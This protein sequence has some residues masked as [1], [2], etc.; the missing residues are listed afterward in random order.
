MSQ[1]DCKRCGDAGYVAG[2]ERCPECQGSPYANLDG[3]TMV[4]EACHGTG[5]KNVPCPEC[6]KK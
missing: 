4:C 1:H 5:H 6:G 2:P 3:Q